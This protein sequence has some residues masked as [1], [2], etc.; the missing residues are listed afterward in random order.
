MIFQNN[1]IEQNAFPAIEK[2]VM[3]P[4]EKDYYKV[5]LIHSV[6]GYFLI[7]V[8]AFLIGFYNTNASWNKIFPF[9]FPVLLMGMGVHFFITKKG[10]SKRKYGIRELD[11]SYTEGLLTTYFY[12]APFVRAQHV[13]IRQGFISKFYK[14]ANLKVFTAGE[15]DDIYIKG[16]PSETAEEIRNFIISKINGE[17]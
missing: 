13:E 14:L 17:V 9:I 8:F 1:Q 11:I 12:T 4:V 7:L 10:F 16:L 6:I 3:L 2:I 5:L 15:G